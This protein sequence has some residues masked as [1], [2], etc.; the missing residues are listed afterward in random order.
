MIN[1]RQNTQ[2]IQSVQ[3][4][5]FSTNCYKNPDNTFFKKTF[6]F[7]MIYD[8]IYLYVVNKKYYERGKSAR[9]F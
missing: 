3:K 4:T 8:I 7:L 2:R 1:F 9:E 5:F 6:T